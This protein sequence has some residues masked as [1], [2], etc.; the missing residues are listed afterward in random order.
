M[1]NWYE[2]LN[3]PVL[4]PPNWVFGMVWPILYVMIAV[5]IVMFVKASWN[6]NAVW[7]YILIGAH[8]CCNFIWTTLFFTLQL[9]G[10]ALVDI[11]VLDVTLVV[12]LLIFW[13]VNKIAG[14]L[15]VP[16]LVWVLFATYL[17][18]AF[19]VLNKA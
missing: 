2:T 15:L 16:Y 1:N 14:A 12:M 7:I 9:P 6:K 10:L 13:K 19:Y 11:V 4:T 3:K 5:S 8:L 17:N 18:A